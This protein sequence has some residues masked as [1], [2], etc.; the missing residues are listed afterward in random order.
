MY[1]LEDLISREFEG[2]PYVF[3]CEFETLHP[4]TDGNGRL[5][6]ALWLRQVIRDGSFVPYRPF[7][8]SFYYATLAGR[9]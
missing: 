7:L 9:R 6:R 4:F 8:Q 1:M 3:H 5:G 2:N